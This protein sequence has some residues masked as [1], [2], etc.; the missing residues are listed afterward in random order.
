MISIRLPYGKFLWFPKVPQE[1]LVTHTSHNILLP[2]RHPFFDSINSWISG[3]FYLKKN[4]FWEG[5]WVI[6]SLFKMNKDLLLHKHD[7]TWWKMLLQHFRNI[8]SSHHSASPKNLSCAGAAIDGRQI[9]GICGAFFGPLLFEPIR[10]K[11]KGINDG[12][13]HG[14][15]WVK[16]KLEFIYT[17]NVLYIYII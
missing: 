10:S 9:V 1:N 16:M 11:W 13:E 8:V 6:S 14:M 17:Y 12:N 2:C 3:G 4:G 5:F 15:I 7:E